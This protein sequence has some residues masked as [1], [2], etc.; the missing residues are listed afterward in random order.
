MRNNKTK[1]HSSDINC[2]FIIQIV[3]ILQEA[4][5]IFAVVLFGSD[6]P[7]PVP[8]LFQQ[9]PLLFALSFFNLCSRYI[10]H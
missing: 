2:T 7:S 3:R 10:F 5:N 9:L 1:R 4:H 8:Q 6:T